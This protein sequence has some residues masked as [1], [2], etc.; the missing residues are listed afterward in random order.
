MLYIKDVH[1]STK[2]FRIRDL[3]GLVATDPLSE[4]MTC[5]GSQYSDGLLV[6]IFFLQGKLKDFERNHLGYEQNSQLI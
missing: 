4:D 5:L 6:V 1:I 2:A 3:R